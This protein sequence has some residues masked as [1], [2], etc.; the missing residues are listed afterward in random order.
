MLRPEELL[1]LDWREL[2]LED[3][4]VEREEK[5]WAR[6]DKRPCNACGLVPHVRHVSLSRG[7][8]SAHSCILCECCRDR[9]VPKGELARAVF[10]PK[11]AHGGAPM[12]ESEIERA[13]EILEAA[14][15]APALRVAKVDLDAL[16][17]TRAKARF[18]VDSK[19][20]DP[21]AYL[22]HKPDLY[23]A[24]C[25]EFGESRRDALC[26]GCLRPFRYR[27]LDVDHVVSWKTKNGSD[28]P[29]NLQLLCPRCNSKKGDASNAEL[30]KRLDMEARDRSDLDFDPKWAERLTDR[31]EWSKKKGEK[32]RN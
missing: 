11:T 17:E 28:D 2:P 21:D 19:H 32:R 16:E 8:L 31:P 3:D 23:R 4:L 26:A 25:G 14:A 27:N 6:R 7:S 13:L 30:H 18:V 20:P 15:L 10:G 5:G 22:V 12:S 1:R 9:A 24:Q 29:E